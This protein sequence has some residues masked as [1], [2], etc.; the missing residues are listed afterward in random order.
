MICTT[1]TWAH[2]WRHTWAAQRAYITACAVCLSCTQIRDTFAR[3]GFNDSETVALIGGGHRFGK[4]HGA[5][6][7]GAGPS[8][9]EDPW[10]PWPGTCG[11][12][13]GVH[14]V[15]SGFEGQWDD[16]PFQWNNFFFG[17]LL[18]FDWEVGCMGPYKPS[19]SVHKK[20]SG[21][22]CLH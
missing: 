13:K 17:N 6:T 9:A 7:T 16:E 1:P 4:A 3:M 8:P 11:N 20:G 14:T 15:T 12:G 22:V 21:C 2:A 10:N 18:A 5:C 19:T